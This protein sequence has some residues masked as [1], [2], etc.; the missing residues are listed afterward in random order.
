[1]D[2]NRSEAVPGANPSVINSPQNPPFGLQTERIS[3]SSFVA[4][5]REKNIHTWIYRIASSLQ[6]G[7]FTPFDE[8]SESTNPLPPRHMTPNSYIWLNIP[9][10]GEA[11]SH[12]ASLI[13]R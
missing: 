1:M 10:D 11:V 8:T 5:S 9:V 6:R 7:D 13:F 2:K 12:F 3:N 4:P